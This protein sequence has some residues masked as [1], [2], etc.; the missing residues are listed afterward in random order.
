MCGLCRFHH[1]LVVYTQRLKSS[2][3]FSHVF[4][5]LGKC[6][7]ASVCN[8]KP[9]PWNM[10]VKPEASAL[11]TSDLSLL[12]PFLKHNNRRITVTASGRPD[13]E[14]RDLCQQVEASQSCAHYLEV[15]GT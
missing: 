1:V 10:W 4:A 11:T 3:N 2:H 7:D 15:H 5:A 8:C 6:Q 12:R 13:H 9:A 14:K